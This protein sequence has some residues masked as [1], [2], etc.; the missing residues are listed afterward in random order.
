MPALPIPATPSNLPLVLFGGN[1]SQLAGGRH[2]R[3]SP[4]TPLANLHLALLDKLGV[5]TV[6]RIGDSTGRLEHLSM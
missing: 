3:Y 1:S 6:E 4:D 2:L 5:P